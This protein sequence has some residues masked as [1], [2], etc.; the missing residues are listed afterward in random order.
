MGLKLK[1]NTANKSYN[2]HNI[3]LYLLFLFSNILYNV[4]LTSSSIQLRKKTLV[5][6]GLNYPQNTLRIDMTDVR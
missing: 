6:K 5:F 1:D 2:K 3:Y 4:I